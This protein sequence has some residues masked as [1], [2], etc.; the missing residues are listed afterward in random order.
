M[1]RLRS[2]RDFIATAA[3]WSAGLA[4]TGA[5]GPFA[6]NAAHAPPQNSIG[7]MNKADVQR[8]VASLK[9]RAIRPGD[10]DYEL[11][12]QV[13]NAAFDK[14]PG[15]IIACSGSADVARTIEFV[16]RH[17]LLMAVRSGGHSLA[18]KST[19]D[20]GVVLDLS[21]LKDIRIDAA[22]RTARAEA[23]LTLAEFDQATQAQGLATTSG[24]EP[25]TGIA[26][27]T[28]GGGLGWLMG[29][30]GLACDNLRSV[31]IVLADGRVLKANSTT[32]E[33][34][35]WAVRG[36]GANF[37]VVTALEYDLH[38]VATILGGVIKYPPESLRD[39]LKHYREFT[40]T[41]PDEV[42]ISVGVIPGRGGKQIASVAVSYCGD[43]KEG[44]KALQSLRSFRPVLSDDIKPMPYLAFQK[45]GGL[46]PGLRLH[47]LI[48]SG[49]LTDL[50]DAA[51][52]VIAAN[53]ATAP[54]FSGSF[55]I[56]YV[57]GKVSR[58]AVT[59][60]AFPHRITGHNFSL[61][62]DWIAP[63]GEASAK[64]WG[65]SFWNAMQPYA[66]SA[67]YSNYLGDE[68]SERARAAYG[69]NYKR[70]TVL[71][72]KYDPSNFFH[73]NQNILPAP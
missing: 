24:T 73:L 4:L 5:A 38:P 53:A 71:K 26:G 37:G 44:E 13:W 57:H 22:K 70:L 17:D 66:R 35:Y 46:P 62:A 54:P 39:V 59:A 21:G 72:R 42:G 60:T 1:P 25:T 28:L 27:L 14:H 40:R 65:I 51:I 47:A 29:K 2:R 49:F 67:V 69:A 18:G 23:G 55:V 64:E 9:G 32:N 19:C 45:L 41:V 52:D 7:Q 15:L 36:A 12:R 6:T 31:D 56:E 20:G 63:S 3:R 68:G 34:L 48:R 50:S 58:T 16:R 43:L 11:A 30:Y 61:H 10:Q 8:F 33:D